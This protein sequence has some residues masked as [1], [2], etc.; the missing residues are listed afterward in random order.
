MRGFFVKAEP[1]ATQAGLAFPFRRKCGV[2]EMQ[3]TLCARLIGKAE[4]LATQQG[5]RIKPIKKP[6]PK[7]GE[8]SLVTSCTPVVK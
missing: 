3:L 8:L 5:L 1:G 7:L 4:G 6:L 2:P